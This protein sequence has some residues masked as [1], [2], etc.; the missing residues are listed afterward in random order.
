MHGHTNKKTSTTP[1]TAPYSADVAQYAVQPDPR[2]DAILRRYTAQRHLQK[3]LEAQ[4]LGVAADA[5]HELQGKKGRKKTVAPSFESGLQGHG[6]KSKNGPPS[7]KAVSIAEIE[8]DGTSRKPQAHTV[9]EIM[10]VVKKGS[11]Y[12]YHVRCKTS[13]ISWFRN[14]GK[15]PA[16]KFEVGSGNSRE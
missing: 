7:L 16:M 3:S 11:G 8:S 9:A 5:A 10:E 15:H 6:K 4:A 13:A 2:I 1:I 12:Q 14:G